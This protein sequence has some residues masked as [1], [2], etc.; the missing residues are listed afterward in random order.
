MKKIQVYWVKSKA[1]D[2]LPLTNVD[3]SNVSDSGVYIIWHR[4]SATIPARVVR[5]GQ[6]DITDRASFHRKDQTVLAYGRFG[7]LMITWA[8]VSVFQRDGVER[9]LAEYWKPLIG[10]RFPDVEPIEVNSP[11]G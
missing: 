5:V 2:W 6:G 9:Y 8:V 3:L 7:D 1:G 4:A 11:W 10:D